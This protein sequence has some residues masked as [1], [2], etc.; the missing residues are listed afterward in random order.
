MRKLI[1][2]FEHEELPADLAK[3]IS[4]PDVISNDVETLIDALRDHARTGARFRYT[5][6]QL[7]DGRFIDCA[8]SAALRWGLTIVKQGDND[9][10]RGR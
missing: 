3:Y 6:A 5:I 4:N 9:E 1:R 7:P 8:R 10:L 2:L